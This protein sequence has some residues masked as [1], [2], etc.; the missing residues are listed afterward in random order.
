MSSLLPHNAT[1]QEVALDLTTARVGGVDVPIRSLWNPE[2]CPADVLPWL[3]WAFSV[4]QWDA[5]WTIEQKR[6][7]VA[8][9]LDIHRRKGTPRAVKAAVT[10]IFGGGDVVEAW[11]SD[12]LDAHEFKIVTTGTLQSDADFAEL[13]RLVDAAKPVRS[14]LVAV[15]IQSAPTS[16]VYLGTASRV[17]G[18]VTVQNRL[19]IDP[20]ALGVYSGTAAHFATRTTINPRAE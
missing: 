6:A 7:I 17:G 16:E 20:G 11:Q 19:A 18:K 12:D 15:Q 8:A 1:P 2:T 13:I 10:A 4:D 9:S 5:A 3:A 14:W